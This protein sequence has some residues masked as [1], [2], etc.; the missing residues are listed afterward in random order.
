ML[1]AGKPLRYETPLNVQEEAKSVF[2]FCTFFLELA[3]FSHGYGSYFL[4]KYST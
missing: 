3:D 1:G 2:L 4:L